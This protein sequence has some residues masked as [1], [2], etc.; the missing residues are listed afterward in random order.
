MCTFFIFGLSAIRRA[1]LYARV[2]CG[3]TLSVRARVWAG[4]RVRDARSAAQEIQQIET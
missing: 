1:T 4:L 3:P 2:R